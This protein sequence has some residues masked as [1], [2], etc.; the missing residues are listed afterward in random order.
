MSRP[1]WIRRGDPLLWLIPTLYYAGLVACATMYI[2][3]L[4]PIDLLLAVCG[5]WSVAAAVVLM[6]LSTLVSE[7]SPWLPLWPITLMMSVA[8]LFFC[9]GVHIKLSTI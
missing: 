2:L 4:D 5:L 1:M 9:I 8:V 3:G 6:A 7:D